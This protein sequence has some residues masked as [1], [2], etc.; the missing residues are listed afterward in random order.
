MPPWRD[1]TASGWPGAGGGARLVDRGPEAP[2][3]AR[4]DGPRPPFVKRGLDRSAKAR[5]PECPD[6]ASRALQG[7]GGLRPSGRVLIRQ[8]RQEPCALPVEQDQELAL[9]Q[10]IPER[11]GR[12]MLDIEREK[13]ACTSSQA[14]LR[15]GH[16]LSLF[17]ASPGPARL[18]RIGYRHVN[19]VHSHEGRSGFHGGERPV[20]SV[21]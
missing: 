18:R 13:V 2:Q 8:D 12:E 9:E 3:Q 16:D 10:A 19:D 20:H 11:L 15:L 7:M 5:D 14:R 4:H 17:G 1:G 6:R 21:W